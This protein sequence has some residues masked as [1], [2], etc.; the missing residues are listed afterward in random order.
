MVSN[1]VQ[2]DPRKAK[3]YIKQSITTFRSQTFFP[4][5]HSKIVSCLTLQC[6]RVCGAGHQLRSVLCRAQHAVPGAA[7]DVLPPR[8]CDA[9]ARPPARRACNSGPCG[10][11]EWVVSSWSGVSTD[12]GQG[13]WKRKSISTMQVRYFHHSYH[14]KKVQHEMVIFL[15]SVNVNFTDVSPPI[16]KENRAI[17]VKNTLLECMCVQWSFRDSARTCEQNLTAPPS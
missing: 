6:N 11:L 4:A 13:R 1:S 2:V 9:S 15:V 14:T 3:E 5:L 10:G 16:S 8:R 12:D 17:F 7:S